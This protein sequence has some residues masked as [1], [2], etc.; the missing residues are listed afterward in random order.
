MTRSYIP[1]NSIAFTKPLS[2]VTDGDQLLNYYFN[3]V[4][5]YN[6]LTAAMAS[7]TTKDQ[8][9]LA[10]MLMS[11]Y[12]TSKQTT[13]IYTKLDGT[14]ATSYMD[15]LTEKQPKL[16]FTVTN[17]DLTLIDVK[18]TEILDDLSA[19]IHNDKLIFMFSHITTVNDESIK[20]YLSKVIAVF[21]S[22]TI[23]VHGLNMVYKIYDPSTDTFRLFDAT[24]TEW[25]AFHRHP[26]N[27][28]STIAIQESTNMSENIRMRDEISIQI[29]RGGIAYEF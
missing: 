10:K 8:Y 20:R 1:I 19:M 18:I 4:S 15:Y 3:N 17:T 11:Y 25:F 12:T 29:L 2:P 7:A 16:A 22:Y 5:V 14:V 26:C 24:D 13:A 9:L 23:D 6:T 28:F 21:K 27:I